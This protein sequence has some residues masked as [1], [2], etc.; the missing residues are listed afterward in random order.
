MLLPLS[1]V[2]DYIKIDDVAPETLAAKLVEIGFEVEAIN[3]L[4]RDIKNVVVGQILSIEKHPNADKLRICR[5]NVGENAPLTIIT[6]ADNVNEGDIVPVAK[7][8]A[9]LPGGK[10]ITAGNLRGILSCGMLCSGSELNIDETV[11]DGAEVDG[12]LVLPK[13][14]AIGADITAALKLHD[15]ILDIS[16]PANRPDCKAF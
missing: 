14:F 4:G 8:G 11:I 9:E 12:I 13:D 2:N 15:C 10:R 5:L 7:D 3:F 16:I 6:G 1:W